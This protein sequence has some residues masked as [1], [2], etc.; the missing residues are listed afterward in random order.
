M[1]KTASAQLIAFLNQDDLAFFGADI[2]TFALM[3]GTTF[4]AT[5]FDRPILYGGNIYPV[6]R[7]ACNRQ[8][9]ISGISQATHAVVSFLLANP[10]TVGDSMLFELVPGM[11]QINGLQGYVTSVSPTTATININSTAFSAYSGSGGKAIMLSQPTILRSKVSMGV[12]LKAS[13]ADVTL[14]ANSEAYVA[15]QPMLTAIAQGMF[16]NAY[17]TIRR[18]FMT[19][20]MVHANDGVLNGPAICTFTTSPNQ[21][22]TLLWF[23]GWVGAVGSVETLKAQLEVRDLIYLLNRP[24]P[25]NLMGP[26]CWHELFDAGCTLSPSGSFG[27]INFT[28]TGAITNATTPTSQ[29][30]STNI[31]VGAAPAAP[32]SAPTI[33]D[34]GN[35]GINIAGQTYWAKVTYVSTTGGESAP[36]PESSLFLDPYH[37]P[38]ILSPPAVSGAIGWNCYLGD[39]KGNEQIQNGAPIAI[40]TDYSAPNVGI[41]QSGQFT[42]AFPS[43][44]YWS[45]GLITFTSGV[46]S[47]L[48]YVVQTSDDGTGLMSLEIPAMVA[49]G[50]ADTFTIRVNCSKTYAECLLKFGNVQ[51]FTGMSWVP[52][53]EQGW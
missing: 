34:N 28:Q 47:G 27:G 26:G 40:G 18:V 35:Q 1:S 25:K 6:A 23:A 51:F 48:S 29:S 39:A 20:A 4:R 30:F 31:M 49:P 33:V 46:L 5:T 12:G 14:I 43:T 3:N 11:T 38:K 2:Y 15:G 21:D 50:V 42:P 7:A 9:T 19:Y 32:V 24:V 37:V 22:A 53:P 45:Q 16:S 13:K 8:Y 36:S 44:G 10:F 41:S 52:V 17:V